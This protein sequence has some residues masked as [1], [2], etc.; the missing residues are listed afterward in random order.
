MINSKI[1]KQSIFLLLNNLLNKMKTELEIAEYR[2]IIE[3]RLVKAESMDAM[4]Y[5][6]GVLRGLEWVVTGLDV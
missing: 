5:Y 6:Q 2:K 3:E 4:K 1:L